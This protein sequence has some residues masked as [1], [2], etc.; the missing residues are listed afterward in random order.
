M[1]Q[2]LFFQRSFEINSSFD[3][4]TKISTNIF[5]LTVFPDTKTNSSA[6]SAK[7]RYTTFEQLQRNTKHA[8]TMKLEQ[9]PQ[10][11]QSKNYSKK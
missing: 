1:N 6:F 3:P 5:V 7:C 9:K 2:T 4:Y 11:N 8:K 10:S